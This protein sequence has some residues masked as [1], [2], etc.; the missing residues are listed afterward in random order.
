MRRIATVVA[1]VLVLSTLG[2]HIARADSKSVVAFN[3]DYLP[4]PMEIARGDTL[5]L[6]NTDSLS[7]PGHSF[8]HAV[9]V[10]ERRF[11][12]EITALGSSSD[13]SGTSDLQPGSYP[14]TCEIHPFMTGTLVVR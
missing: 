4:K 9:P 1:T 13:V 12:S 5:R 2:P 6:V 10:G 3:F 11:D 7:G 14:V 8:T